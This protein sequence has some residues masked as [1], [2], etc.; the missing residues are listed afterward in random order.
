MDLVHRFFPNPEGARP[1]F[2]SIVF[3]LTF[4]ALLTATGNAAGI[5]PLLSQQLALDPLTPDEVALATRI[6]TA[7]PR[8]NES[9]GRGR[10]QLIQVQFVTPKM[11]TNATAPQENESLSVRRRAAVIFY[12]YDTNQGIYAVIDLQLRSVEEITKVPGRGV[13][14]A[15]EEVSQAF[16]L[17]SL[18][19]RVKGFLGSQGSEFTVV[20]PS[21]GEQPQNRVEGLRVISTGPRDPCNKHRCIELMFRKRGEYVRGTSVMVDLSAQTVNVQNTPR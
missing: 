10:K 14:L 6:A 8:V 20:Q 9:L 5:Q 17:A 13:P 12:R 7:D 1:V 4:V 11:G 3:A 21:A 19:K 2:F 18:N 15:L 16:A